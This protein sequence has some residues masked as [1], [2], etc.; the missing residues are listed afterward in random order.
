MAR[1]PA[2]LRFLVRTVRST[3]LFCSL[4]SSSSMTHASTVSGSQFSASSLVADRTL[5]VSEPPPFPP[6]LNSLT[7]PPEGS[8]PSTPAVASSG[9]SSA[10]S[11]VQPVASPPCCAASSEKAP[12]A[13]M[14]VLKVPLSTT[15]PLLSTYITSAR[16][17]VLSRWAMRRVVLEAM[18]PSR[19]SCTTF[20]LSL[21]RALVASSSRSIF[22]LR[23]IARAIAMRCFCP[24]DS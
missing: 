7:S 3:M 24:P 20:S 8:F 6:P 4:G 23:M 10:T 21:S 11:A 15:D 13:D 2:P 14:S 16:R 9:M 22:G 5:S 12:P 19:A 18:I 1:S 17:T